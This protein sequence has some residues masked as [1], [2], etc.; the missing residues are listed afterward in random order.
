MRSGVNPVSVVVATCSTVSVSYS[1]LSA[2]LKVPF[3]D[4]E[5]L[6]VASVVSRELNLFPLGLPQLLLDT[7]PLSKD[8]SIKSILTFF[9]VRSSLC[10]K[11]AGV[12][13]V[14]KEVSWAVEMSSLSDN[15]TQV[16]LQADLETLTALFSIELTIRTG[17]RPILLLLTLSDLP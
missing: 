4:S 6:G 12:S 1:P 11:E 5:T 16:W 13:T 17:Y 10:L 3:F 14:P 9:W 8:L 7:D 2:L 15:T